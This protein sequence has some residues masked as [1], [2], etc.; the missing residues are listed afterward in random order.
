[1]KEKNLIN[2][3]KLDT[4]EPPIISIITAVYNGEEHIE[5]TIESVRIQSYPN[6]EHIVI[7]GASDD[8][9]ME[10][11]KSHTASIT[12]WISEP[13]QGVYSAI[14]KGIKISTGKYIL[15]LNSGDFFYD[16]GSLQLL[17]SFIEKNNHI[18]SL[19][20]CMYFRKSTNKYKKD[21]YKD[22]TPFTFPRKTISHQALL[23]RKSLHTKHGLYNERYRFA[24]DRDFFYKI[25][26][27][28]M[29]F[30]KENHCVVVR[31]KYGND[32]TT[33][34]IQF[35]VEALMIDIHYHKFK[36]WKYLDLAIISLVKQS[37]SILRR[38]IW[39]L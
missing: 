24:A 4:I 17:F 32:L 11:V 19:G 16:S 25:Q 1:M 14:N 2:N 9:T 37:L 23:Y 35:P 20:R 7:D 31:G 27:D 13:D 12:H 21:I 30:S 6:V 28:I 26:K 34:A 39:K 10:I 18:Y 33:T 15:V 8:R 3:P 29:L 38:K 36:V 22:N 5:K